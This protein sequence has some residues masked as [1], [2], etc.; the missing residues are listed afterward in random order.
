MRRQGLIFGLDTTKLLLVVLA[1]VVAIWTARLAVARDKNPWAWGGAALI[2]GIPWPNIGLPILGI[3]PVLFLM[4]FVRPVGQGG[5]RPQPAACSR[6]ASPHSPGQNFCTKCGWDLSRE[7]SPEGSD[8][9]LAS[10]MHQAQG[11]TT[12]T[13]ERPVEAVKAGD[14]PVTDYPPPESAEAPVES[15]PA[16]TTAEDDTVDVQPS[17]P[18]ET[19]EGD[20]TSE[21]VSE[22]VPEGDP[23]LARPWG[24]PQPGP[25]PTAAVMT[26]RGEALLNEGRLQEAI[27]QFTKAIA[28]DPRHREAFERRAEAYTK[29]GRD[30]RAAE[31]YRRV[32]ALIT[33]T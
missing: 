26:A 10:E 31:D 30:E 29:Q 25:A 14:I 19:R 4:F 22:P 24:I 8:T 7:Y 32:Q 3:V 17:A 15:S 16:E 9:V 18:E 2:L 6:C 28:L 23:E 5:S 12:A 21:P 11:S 13:V 20:E 33:G 1:I 27:D